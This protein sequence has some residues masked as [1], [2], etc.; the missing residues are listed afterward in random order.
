MSLNWKPGN[1]GPWVMLLE[2]L[3]SPAFRQHKPQVL[4]WQ[5]FEPNFNQGPD[6]AGL[7]D[8]ASVMPNAT[9]LER[10]GK[11]QRG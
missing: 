4:V 6:A 1:I 11:A 7:W 5:M 10:V 9:W 3:E 2:Y 8:N